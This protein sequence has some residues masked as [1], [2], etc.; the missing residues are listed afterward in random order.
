M[1]LKSQKTK[2]YFHDGSP[3]TECHIPSGRFFMDESRLFVGLRKGDAHF[4]QLNVY[5]LDDILNTDAE[6]KPKEKFSIVPKEKI[7]INQRFHTFLA[8]DFF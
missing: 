6:N 1:I 8:G 5:H 3:A 2:L 4:E 7:E